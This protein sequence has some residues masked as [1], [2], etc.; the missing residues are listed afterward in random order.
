MNVFKQKNE[1]R[2]MVAGG[3]WRAEQ[4]GGGVSAHPSGASKRAAA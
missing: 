2:A 3:T 4:G 1:M